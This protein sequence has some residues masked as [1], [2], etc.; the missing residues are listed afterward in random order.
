MRAP[1]RYRALLALA[2]FAALSL[3]FAAVLAISDRAYAVVFNALQLAVALFAALIA[4][5]MAAGLR[6]AWGRV[7]GA[8]AAAALLG[9]AFAVLGTDRLWQAAPLALPLALWG[10]WRRRRAASPPATP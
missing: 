9:A 1:R 2:A 8:V 6:S 10:E 4:V 5:E 7:A 3:A